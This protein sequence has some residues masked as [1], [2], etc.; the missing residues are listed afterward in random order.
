MCSR[1][2]T[3]LVLGSRHNKTGCL[4]RV[5]WSVV[6]GKGGYVGWICVTRRA[7]APQNRYTGAEDPSTAHCTLVVAEPQGVR[8]ILNAGV[9]GV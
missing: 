4:A 1:A 7:R 5:V 2:H 9:R 3:C 8:A 6:C